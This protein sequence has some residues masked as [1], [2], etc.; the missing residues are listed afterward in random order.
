M[1]WIN[2]KSVGLRILIGLT[3]FGPDAGPCQVCPWRKG[4][5]EMVAGSRY[6]A[7]G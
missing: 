6:Y 3:L 7:F 1:I 5:Q 2:S 4:Q